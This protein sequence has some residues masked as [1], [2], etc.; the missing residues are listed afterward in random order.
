MICLSPPVIFSH[1]AVSYRALYFKVSPVTGR[2]AFCCPGKA[3]VSEV[4]FCFWLGLFNVCP[5]DGCYRNN[6]RV[7][8]FL[9]WRI[10]KIFPV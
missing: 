2:Q 8:C 9:L 1:A 4:C 10:R 3:E 7:T 5:L 6:G